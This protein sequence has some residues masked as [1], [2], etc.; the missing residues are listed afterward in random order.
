MIEPFYDLGMT[1]DQLKTIGMIS[2]NWSI[3]DR[4]ITEILQSFY[5]FTNWQDVVDLVAVLDFDKKLHLCQKKL[6][7]NQKPLGYANADWSSVC[8]LLDHLRKSAAKFR[9]G[10]NHVIHG[11]V[12][13]F[14]GNVR[15]P[16]ILSH[17][18]TLTIELTELPKIFEQ[19]AYLTH[20]MAHLSAV[21]YGHKS[22]E[23]LPCIQ[24]RQTQ[25]H[26]ILRTTTQKTK[27]LLLRAPDLSPA[28]RECA[29]DQPPEIRRTGVFGG[30]IAG[31]LR[32]LYCQSNRNREELTLWRPDSSQSKVQFAHVC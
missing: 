25:M 21:L 24:E 32:K 30:V 18:K 22:L 10:R 27:A 16:V 19:S 13:H 20:V 5:S 31:V 14:F 17:K 23:P 12:V 9:N 28:K 2:L 4:E 3:V 15:D 29:D 7:Q 11:T 8:Q 6:E 26:R 1:D